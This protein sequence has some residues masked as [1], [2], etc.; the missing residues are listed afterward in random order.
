MATVTLVYR[1]SA[2]LQNP[3]AFATLVGDVPLFDGELDLLGLDVVSDDTIAIP[4]DRVAVRT[5]VLETNEQG[6]SL[7]R[8]EEQLKLATRQLYTTELQ[9]RI[10]GTS[11]ADE[12]IVVGLPVLSPEEPQCPPPCA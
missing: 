11:T 1:V 8:T 9:L 2:G 4:A 12:P 10:P 3:V 7:W 5:I 6:D